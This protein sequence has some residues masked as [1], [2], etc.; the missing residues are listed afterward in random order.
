MDSGS[1]LL[2][3]LRP[4]AEGGHSGILACIHTLEDAAAEL[5]IE[6]GDDGATAVAGALSLAAPLPI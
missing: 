4:V 2:V 1:P 3:I 6:L 5:A